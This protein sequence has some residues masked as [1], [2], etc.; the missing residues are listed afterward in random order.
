MFDSTSMDMTLNK[1]QEIVKE[2]GAWSI[3][4]MGSKELDTRATEQQQN[5]KSPGQY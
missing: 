4:S 2:R 3:Q 5:S 1:F